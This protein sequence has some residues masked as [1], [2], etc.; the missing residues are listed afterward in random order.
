[1]DTVSQSV[2]LRRVADGQVDQELLRATLAYD[3]SEPYEVRVL[4][5]PGLE[6]M[7]LVLSRELVAGGLNHPV[8]FGGIGVWP[9]LDDRWAVCIGWSTPEGHTWFEALATTV[10]HFLDMTYRLVPWG[11]E[12]PRADIDN[13][14]AAILNGGGAR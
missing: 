12:S 14:I 11:S 4:F 8:T 6:Q 9:S 10:A 2:G 3:R 5:P 13:V 7:N 1:M